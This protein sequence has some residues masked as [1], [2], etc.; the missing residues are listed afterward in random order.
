MGSDVSLSILPSQERSAPQVS[1]QVVIVPWLWRLLIGITQSDCLP[2][3]LSSPCE[4]LV[5]Q[6]QL[7]KS[8]EGPL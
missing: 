5:N 7:R 1:N 3:K 4:W 6:A 2:P 8:Q